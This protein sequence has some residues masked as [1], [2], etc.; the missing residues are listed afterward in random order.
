MDLLELNKKINNGEI[1]I[2]D[3]LWAADYRYYNVLTIPV[4]DI[5]P[6]LVQIIENNHPNIPPNI[7]RGALDY[8]LVPV[9]KRGLLF[10][11]TFDPK[12][13]RGGWIFSPNVFVHQQDCKAFY[14]TQ[15]EKILS[16]IEEE[17]YRIGEKLE[18]VREKVTVNMIKHTH[19]DEL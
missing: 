15:C 3:R 4:R 8:W 6:Q 9:G 5:P 7:H 17:H 1:K 13:M 12:P 10:N 11:K 19:R 2:G 16:Q 18:K 14:K